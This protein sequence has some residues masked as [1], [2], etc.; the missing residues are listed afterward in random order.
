MK[1]E[2]WWGLAVGVIGPR[3]MELSTN[4]LVWTCSTDYQAQQ[5]DS[6]YAAFVICEFACQCFDTWIVPNWTVGLDDLY[7]SCQLFESVLPSTPELYCCEDRLD[8][9]AD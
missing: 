5:V 4:C 6:L 3:I 2:G 8:I 9:I 1:E 7:Y